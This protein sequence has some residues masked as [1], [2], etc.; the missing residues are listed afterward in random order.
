MRP[1]AGL[2]LLSVI[3]LAQAAPPADHPILGI[4]KLSLPDLSCSETYRFRGDGTTLVTSAE[5]V[6]ESEYRIPDKPS[7][8][9]YYRLEDRIVK[10]NGKKD[11]SGAIM[12]VGTKAINFIRFHPSGAIFLMCADE[13]MNACIG[14]FER[15]KGEEA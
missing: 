4:W 2:F 6:S 13:T 1:L 7:A 12:K 9:G 3:H 11:C 5:E 10:D 14:P 8:K 15:V